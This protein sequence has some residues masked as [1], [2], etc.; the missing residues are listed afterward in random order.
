MTGMVLVDIRLVFRWN[1]Q[2]SGVSFRIVWVLRLVFC[3][4][5]FVCFNGDC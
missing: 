5:W 3:F 4:W 1:L 2:F